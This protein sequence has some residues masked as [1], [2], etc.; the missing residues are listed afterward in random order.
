MPLY[1]LV[2][3]AK[4]RI[5][6]RE[7]TDILRTAAQRV[8]SDKGVVTNVTSFGRIGL[9][10]DIRKR[11]GLHNQGQL[12]QMTVMAPPSL[13]R[14]LL[15]LNKDDRLLRWLLVRSNGAKWL[16]GAAP[17]E[18]SASRASARASTS[19]ENGF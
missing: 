4:S 15:Y 17:K 18:S 5:S 6:A 2:V 12:V 11:D 10:Y 13:P 9:A 16:R 1:D 8:F 14:D 7:I 3:V 19:F